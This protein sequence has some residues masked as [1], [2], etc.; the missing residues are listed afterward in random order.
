MDEI[1][2]TVCGCQF[3]MTQNDYDKNKIVVDNEDLPLPSTF[4]IELNDVDLDAYTNTDGYTIRNRVREDVESL[5]INYGVLN[6]VELNQLLNITK[7]QWMNVSWFS[8]KENSRVTHK[9]YRS[10]INY[11][12]YFVTSDPLECRYTNIVFTFVQQ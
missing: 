5:E 4:P 3:L 12:K 6:G 11:E 10:K 8:E 9:F 2:V 1:I 7:K